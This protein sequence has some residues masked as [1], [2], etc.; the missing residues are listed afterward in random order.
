MEKRRS[1]RREERGEVEGEGEGKSKD[2]KECTSEA[3]DHVS[4][5]IYTLYA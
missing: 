3:G 5:V 4:F 1:D 2:R